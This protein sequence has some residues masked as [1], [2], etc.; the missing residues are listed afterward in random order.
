MVDSLVVWRPEAGK[1]APL[2]RV[3]EMT[4]AAIEPLGF[5]LGTDLLV[6]GS[7]VASALVSGLAGVVYAAKTNSFSNSIGGPMLFPAFARTGQVRLRARRSAAGAPGD[8]LGGAPDPQ[9]TTA[10]G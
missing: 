1:R 4:G 3:P 9:A 10:D 8:A 7:L 2:A 6:V 5:G